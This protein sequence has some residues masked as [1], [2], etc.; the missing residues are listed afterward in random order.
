M[1]HVKAWVAKRL[2]TLEAATR[3]AV[4][5]VDFT[6][7]RLESVLRRFGHDDRWCAFEAARNQHTVLVYDLSTDRGHVANTSARVY[8]TCGTTPQ[9]SPNSFEPP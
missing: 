7:D 1:V 8:A 5:R 6:D 9:G 2:W 3:Q 4:N